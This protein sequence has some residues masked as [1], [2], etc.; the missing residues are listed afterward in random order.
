MEGWGQ[1]MNEYREKS[2][3]LSCKQPV[4]GHMRSSLRIFLCII[5]LRI[6]ELT[7]L[8]LSN[9]YDPEESRF[10]EKI[11]VIFLTAWVNSSSD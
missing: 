6:L 11:R 3:G 5:F 10:L 1:R 9:V 4:K 2:H 7:K 8:P